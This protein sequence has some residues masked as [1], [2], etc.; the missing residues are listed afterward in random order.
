MNCLQLV[1][2]QFEIYENDKPVAA[3]CRKY[4]GELSR[5]YQI[6]LGHAIILQCKG[7][8]IGS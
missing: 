6:L 8:D 3:H 1:Q 4:T 2:P 7:P 5:E